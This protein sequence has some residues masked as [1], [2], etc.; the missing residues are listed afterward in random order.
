MARPTKMSVQ[1][2]LR[3][4]KKSER[5]ESKRA[6]RGSQDPKPAGGKV[7]EREDLEGYGVVPTFDGR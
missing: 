6:Q 3:E 4:Q 7:A 1:K 5:A 2:R